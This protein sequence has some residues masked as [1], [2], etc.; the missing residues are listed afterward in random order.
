AGEVRGK[1]RVS[2]GVYGANTA[3]A[4]LGTLVSTLVLI[5]AC[6]FSGTLLC[7]AGMNAVCALGA[8]IIRPS[9]DRTT[10]ASD[11]APTQAIGDLR[12]TVTLFV[13]GLLGIA[14]EVL[15]VRLAAQ[16]MQNTVYTF[17]GL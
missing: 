16:V 15:V 4:V 1:T 17:A 2:A 13:T 9:A 11:E 7:L 12:L 10:A 8:L 6:G 5:P 14:F 3:G